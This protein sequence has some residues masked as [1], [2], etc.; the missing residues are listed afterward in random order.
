MNNMI[1]L[2]KLKRKAAF[3]KTCIMKTVVSTSLCLIIIL[4]LCAPVFAEVSK[5]DKY[6]EI[7]RGDSI[8]DYDGLLSRYRSNSV[9]FRRNILNYQ[10][11]ALNGELADENHSYIN[12][13]H[14]DVLGKIVGKYFFLHLLL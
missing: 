5:T 13:Q 8:F 3:N 4:K 9:T 11:E 10:I 14:I 2:L 6:Y 7:G 1:K 12:S